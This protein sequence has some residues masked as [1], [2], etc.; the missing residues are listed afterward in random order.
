M[1]GENRVSVEY[2]EKPSGHTSP[3]HTH[4][5]KQISIV[6][7]GK[8]KAYSEEDEV[9]LQE[10]DSVFFDENEPHRIENITKEK[11]VGI[12]IFVPGR[13]FDFWAKHRSS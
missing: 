11:A 3:M 2:Y 7:K 9:E 5:N 13:S 12:D 4:G 1:A 8:M 10:M 6:I